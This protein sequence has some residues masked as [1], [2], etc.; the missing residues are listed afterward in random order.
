MFNDESRKR[1]RKHS[2]TKK[3]QNIPKYLGKNF[4]DRG[5]TD[6]LSIDKSR[7]HCGI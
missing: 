3:E 5:I 1:A 4:E 2:K 7:N 6:I